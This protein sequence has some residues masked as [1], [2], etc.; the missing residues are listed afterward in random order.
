M[1]LLF[2]LVTAAIVLI[3]L[4]IFAAVKT[5]PH[6]DPWEIMDFGPRPFLNVAVAIAIVGTVI[7]GIISSHIPVVT[8]TK[9]TKLQPM[10]GEAGQ[11]QVF[12]RISE[13]RGKLEYYNFQV[14]N[15]DGSMSLHRI[16]AENMVLFEDVEPGQT[17]EF[18]HVFTQLD[19]SSKLLKWT[20]FKNDSDLVRYELHIPAGTALIFDA[21]R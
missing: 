3:G 19:Q 5:D 16:H 7:S 18:R 4:I 13:Y 8:V 10:P 15:Q 14:L 6:E 1:Y 11:P 20:W 12:V 21:R 17:S 2:A 9:A